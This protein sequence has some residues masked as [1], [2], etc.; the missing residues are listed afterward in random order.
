MKQYNTLE[1]LKSEIRNSFTSFAINLKRIVVFE[2]Y[3]IIDVNDYDTINIEN[4][5][6]DFLDISNIILELQ[7]NEEKQ[8]SKRFN[9]IYIN[10]NAEEI[11]VYSNMPTRGVFKINSEGIYERISNYTMKDIYFCRIISDSGFY[12]LQLVKGDIEE[13]Q[14]VSFGTD[15]ITL[16]ITLKKCI[17]HQ[18]YPGHTKKDIKC[19]YEIVNLAYDAGIGYLFGCYTDRPKTV[20]V[21]KNYVTIVN[22]DDFDYWFFPGITDDDSAMLYFELNKDNYF[23][24]EIDEVEESED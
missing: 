19:D 5:N 8:N 22:K 10:E 3:Y 9:K 17:T 13:V 6:L 21:E 7:K 4:L 20:K 15:Q 1:E 16:K 14:K 23:E 12:D 24:I 18:L 11:Y 2:S